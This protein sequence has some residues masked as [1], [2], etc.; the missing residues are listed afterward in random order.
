M[1]KTLI[2][3]I[4]LVI[5]LGVIA[6]GFF[7]VALPLYVQSIGV[8]AQT[9]TVANTN[10]VYQAQ[11]DSLTAQ[12]ENLDQINASVAGLRAQIPAK[13]QLDD[14]FEVIARAT[15][16]SQ[17]TLTSVTA[18]EQ[19]VFVPRTG[20]DEAA[21]AAAVPAPDATPTPGT[22]GTGTAADAPGASDGAPARTAVGRQQVDFAIQATAADM[23][24]VT[25]FLD[26]L[27][28]GPRLLGSVMV[29]TNQSGGG[30]I[31]ILI[32]ALTYIDAEG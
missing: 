26:A 28:T 24:Q 30:M 6:L 29:T 18:G 27:R 4:G 25:A 19:V 3:V 15:E 9:A 31:D 2:T 23:G 12:Q 10:A 14:V 5:S 7:L 21:D 1:S 20:A 13:G 22:D 16:A 8:D 32:E 11:V 17:V